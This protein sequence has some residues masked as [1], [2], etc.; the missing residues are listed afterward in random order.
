MERPRTVGTGYET[1]VG[2][3]ESKAAVSFLYELL[4]WPVHGGID[5]QSAQY[6]MVGDEM[7]SSYPIGADSE[8]A[9]IPY[10]GGRIEKL[11][12]RLGRLQQKQCRAVG[13]R[14]VDNRLGSNLRRAGHKSTRV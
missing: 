13:H 7:N 3:L 9:L 8:V 12:P 11:H 5:R 1:L 10:A 4:I 2:Y 6:G 14:T